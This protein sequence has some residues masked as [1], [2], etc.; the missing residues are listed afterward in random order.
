MKKEAI[1]IF[2]LLVVSALFIFGCQIPVGSQGGWA[3]YEEDT[4]E[5]TDI[6]E[7]RDSPEYMRYCADNPL[8]PQCPG[9]LLP[10]M[11][12]SA[13][14]DKPGYEFDVVQ[15]S[16]DLERG[17]ED[18]PESLEDFL[19]QIEGTE[20]AGSID[21]VG[22][23]ESV[24]KAIEEGYMERT[25]TKLVNG[26][27]IK[28]YQVKDKTGEIVHES[29][30]LN[31]RKE[32]SG[33]NAK[34]IGDSFHRVVRFVEKGSSSSRV[35]G[36]ILYLKQSYFELF[37]GIKSG[38]PG[39][40]HNIGAMISDPAIRREISKV[41]DVQRRELAENGQRRTLQEISYSDYKRNEQEITENFKAKLNLILYGVED[42]RG[43]DARTDPS[44]YTSNPLPENV[45]DLTKDTVFSEW[46]KSITP[47]EVIRGLTNYDVPDNWIPRTSPESPRDTV[48]SIG[49]F[50]RVFFGGMTNNPPS[51]QDNAYVNDYLQRRE[52]GSPDGLSKED[53]TEILLDFQDRVR[54]SLVIVEDSKVMHEAVYG[55]KPR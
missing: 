53:K 21:A 36:D 41:I 2:S 35:D 22:D 16:D 14:R 45:V 9:Y 7:Y 47:E 26:F 48:D 34:G 12:V 15:A 4:S 39:D 31:L 40:I 30:V 33:E 24:W 43:F 37:L 29:Y 55:E 49:S 52:L 32:F 42:P 51:E 46:A 6:Y 10:E 19:I 13:E 8:D 44:V 20:L 17:L 5:I 50:V 11:V 27:K 28:V 54:T 18:K 38:N 3:P 1:L 25:I 23:S